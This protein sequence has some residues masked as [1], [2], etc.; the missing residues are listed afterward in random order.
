MITLDSN[1]AGYES[2]RNLKL[3]SNLRNDRK[4]AISGN[5]KSGPGNLSF[6][7]MFRQQDGKWIITR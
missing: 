7:I 1:S 2:E 5:L 3:A 4:N 6:P